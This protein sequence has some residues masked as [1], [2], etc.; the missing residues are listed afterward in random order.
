MNISKNA[1]IVAVLESQILGLEA[2]VE[3]YQQDNAEKEAK[4]QSHKG[5]DWA[6]LNIERQIVNIR[7]KIEALGEVEEYSGPTIEMRVFDANPPMLTPDQIREALGLKAPYVPYEDGFCAFKNGKPRSA[8]PHKAGLGYVNPPSAIE[9]YRGWD[10]AAEKQ[11]IHPEELHKRRMKS[12]FDFGRAAFMDGKP[13]DDNPQ[14]VE[15][16]RVEQDRG[17]LCAKADKTEAEQKGAFAESQ[18][19]SDYDKGVIAFKQGKPRESNPNIVPYEN[20]TNMAEVNWFRGWDIAESGAS[21]DGSATIGQRNQTASQTRM[22]DLGLEEQ[23]AFR[24]HA[25]LDGSIAALDGKS[26]VENPFNV[27]DERYPQ[28]L[29]GYR[30]MLFKS[31]Q[32]EAYKEGFKAY[33]PGMETACPSELDKKHRKQW[34]E[35]HD[36]ARINYTYGYKAI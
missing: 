18:N 35:G 30:S 7:K 14:T 23:K 27:H 4:G 11:A 34:Q 1:I 9:W 13:I 16:Y 25:R 6:V 31:P 36:H 2:L 33:Q 29:N 15:A 22:I 3:A 5:S 17:W 26:S 8:N 12:A 10:A 32:T 20:M 21:I 19:L 28:W 24:G